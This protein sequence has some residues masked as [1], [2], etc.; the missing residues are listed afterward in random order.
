MPFNYFFA[1]AYYDNK[2]TDFILAEY[3]KGTVKTM[4]ENRNSKCFS[5]NATAGTVCITAKRVL[6]SCKDRDCF[7][8]S[9]VYLTAEGENILA[10]ATNVRTKC[11]HLVWAYVGVN[12]IPFNR[13]FFQVTV[14]YFIKVELEA[15]L[16]IGRSQCFSGI[17][18][19]E[20][21]VILYGGEG[22]AISYSSTP[23]SGYCDIGETT[24]NT[25][26]PIAVVETVAPV[27]L[28]TKIVENSCN[29]CECSCCEI[30]ESICGCLGGNVIYNGKSNSPK[31]YISFGIF[32]VIRI[33]REAQ[34]LIQATDYSVPDKECVAATSDN[35]PCALFSTM[36]FPTSQFKTTTARPVDTDGHGGSGCGCQN[37]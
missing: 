6:D 34:L 8:D 14:R 25:N 1:F 11:A 23:G 37:K 33:E 15:Y 29:P 22:G 13:G 19:L 18:A 28:G 9:R 3:C 27:V 2:A 32:S 20:K 7:E 17:C 16:G 35:N 26:D 21:D 4:Q 31:L 12:E 30:P 10:N 24:P 5:G 36:P